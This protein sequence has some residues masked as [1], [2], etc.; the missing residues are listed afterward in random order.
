MKPIHAIL[1]LYTV[2]M[3]FFAA[4]WLAMARMRLSRRAT[5]HWGLGTLLLAG[6]MAVVLARP[7][8]PE[9]LGRALPNLV[10]LAAALLVARGVRLFVRRPPDD[11]LPLVLAAL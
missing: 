6:G 3:A 1:A 10:H 7:W 8:L 2:Q 4:I 9:A 11:R 5:L